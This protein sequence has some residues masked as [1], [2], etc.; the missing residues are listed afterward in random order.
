M[1]LILAAQFCEG[2]TIGGFSDWYMPAKNELG[3]L[4]LQFKTNYN[5]AITHHQA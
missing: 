5:I 1:Q 3:S 2:L 4:L